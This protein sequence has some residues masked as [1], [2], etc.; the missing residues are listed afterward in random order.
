MR[1]SGVGHFLMLEDLDGFN[2]LLEQAVRK[3]CQI[4]AT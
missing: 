4:D 1:M 3:L 2:R